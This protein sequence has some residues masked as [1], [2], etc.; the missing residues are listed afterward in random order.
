MEK[1]LK[2]SSPKFR[3]GDCYR[4]VTLAMLV[5]MSPLPL[6][7]D[8]HLECLCLLPAPLVPVCGGKIRHAREGVRM[9]ISEH[10]LPLLHDHHLE[11]LCLLPVPLLPV[12]A[13]KIR[14][15]RKAHS[16]IISAH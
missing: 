7:R 15:V 8:H 6:L 11:R 5:R 16:I 10:L 4:S 2:T 14:H 13:C 9:I 12:R 1:E 3:D